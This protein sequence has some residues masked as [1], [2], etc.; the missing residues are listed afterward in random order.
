MDM[1]EGWHLKVRRLCIGGP[2]RRHPV[3]PFFGLVLIYIFYGKTI[4]VS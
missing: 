3:G 2:P 4:V 1:P